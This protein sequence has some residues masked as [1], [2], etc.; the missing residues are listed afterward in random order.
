VEPQTGDKAFDCAAAR[1][2][3]DSR[4]VRTVLTIWLTIVGALVGAA[5]AHATLPGANGKIV[6]ASWG[7]IFM[8]NPDGSGLVQVQRPDEDEKR[9]W[10]PAWSPDGTHIATTGEVLEPLRD[11][12]PYRLWSGNDI[13]VFGA[14]GSGF[15]HFATPRQHYSGDVAWSPGG[16]RIA[17]TSDEVGNGSIYIVRADGSDPQAIL[18]GQSGSGA[19]DPAWSPDGKWIAIARGVGNHETDLYLIR[20]DGT[21]LHKLLE[22]PGTETGPSWSPDGTTIVFS[23]SEWRAGETGERDSIFTVPAG[24]GEVTRLTTGDHDIGPVWSPD[25]SQ[26]VLERSPI[27]P[28]GTDERRVWVMDAD[29]RN[30]Y[31]ITD[32]CGQCGP[33][34]QRVAPLGPTPDDKDLFP[35]ATPTSTSV[36]SPPRIIVPAPVPRTVVGPGRLSRVTLAPT[37]FRWRARSAATLRL[38]LSRPTRVTFSVNRSGRAKALR[39]VARDL[40]SGETTLALTSLLPRTLTPGG[41]VVTARGELRGN[42]AHRA[43]RVLKTTRR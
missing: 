1:N 11:Y 29:G 40:P 25:G 9:D 35:T 36:P 7:E 31:S 16:T 19:F 13:H 37:R 14:D 23:G 21:G 33:D 22:R 28:E 43:F 3:L 24:G 34:W 41:Y 4:T 20:P 17:Y 27:V 5:D 30:A 18:V 26:I 32:R 8:V 2:T 42:V 39:T 10:Y 6:F 38:S 12:L 15:K